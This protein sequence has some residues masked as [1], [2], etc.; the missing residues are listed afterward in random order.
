VDYEGFLLESELFYRYVNKLGNLESH[1]LENWTREQKLAFWINAYNAFTLQAIMKRYPISGRSLIGLFFPQNSILQIPGIWSRIEFKAGGKK[2][3]LG[4]IEHKIIRKLFDE[5]RIHFAIVC[6]S[7]SCANLR[8]ETYQANILEKQLHEQADQFINDPSKGVRWDSDNHRLSISKIF[9]WFKKDFEK[10]DI[11]TGSST[12]STKSNQPV[13]RFIRQYIRNK[14]VID[15]IDRGRDI[16]VSY[17]PYDWRLNDKVKK[18]H[19]DN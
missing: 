2:V 4:Q 5:P 11:P 3:T 1:V 15:R 19:M 17:L 13:L 10:K 8:A 12:R 16:R 14:K 18:P 6:A 7:R 9:K